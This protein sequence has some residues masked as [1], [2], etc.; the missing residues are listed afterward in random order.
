[1]N[2]A[3]QC[4]WLQ[5]I[6][7]ERGIESETFNV[8]YC[9]NKSTIQISTDPVQ[10]KQ[11]NYID[12]HIHYTRELVHDGAIALLYCTSSKKVA[13]I[14]TKVFCEKTFINIKSLLRITNHVVNNY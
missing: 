1:M 8:I 4:L 13:D 14:F 9:G 6:I 7:G 2:A 11:T 3:T 10:I 12:I 5:G